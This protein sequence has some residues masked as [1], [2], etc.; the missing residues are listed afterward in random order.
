[1]KKFIAVQYNTSDEYFNKDVSI[2]FVHNDREIE[3]IIKDDTKNFEDD[4]ITVYSYKVR[5][6]TRDEIITYIEEYAD[7][8]DLMCIVEALLD[9]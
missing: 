3:L 9:L 4:S 5:E 8:D 1:M 2:Y 6:A 7:R